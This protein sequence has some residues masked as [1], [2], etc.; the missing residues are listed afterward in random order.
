LR[1]GEDR[2]SV[3]RLLDRSPNIPRD[4]GGEI[5]GEVVELNRAVEDYTTSSVEVR[6]GE[7]R[8]L[9]EKYELSIIEELKNRKKNLETMVVAEST[10][11]EYFNIIYDVK[12][13]LDRNKLEATSEN[14]LKI[15]RENKEIQEKL[16]E[17]IGESL[18][19]IMIYRNGEQV[20][21]VTKYANLETEEK[22]KEFTRNIVSK[23]LNEDGF[24]A[25]ITQGVKHMEKGIRENS[26]K[27]LYKAYLY[28]IRL[29]GYTTATALLEKTLELEA[30]EKPLIRYKK[31]LELKTKT[32]EHTRTQTRK[33]EKKTT[34][35]VMVNA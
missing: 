20:N 5:Y 35:E 4:V 13:Q 32:V 17:S 31:H 29:R 2:E 28:A 34:G 9:A 18:S 23:L 7:I 11:R 27:E 19:K 33:P 16:A 14:I 30:D 25:I 24:T 15:L 8:D 26:D 6:V 1:S 10:S 21:P 3:E 12:K 22:L